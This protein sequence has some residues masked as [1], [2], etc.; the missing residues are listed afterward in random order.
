MTVIIPSGRIPLRLLLMAAFVIYGAASAVSY[1][2]VVTGAVRQFPEPWG[3]LFIAALAVGGACVLIAAWRNSVLS[4]LALER[5]AMLLVGLMSLI[6]AGWSLYITGTNS[7]GFAVLLV[8][9]GAD[10][11]WRVTEIEVARRVARKERP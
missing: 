6:Y 2:R 11:A 1:N 8:A 5:S 10:C 7:I 9:V 4:T 3:R